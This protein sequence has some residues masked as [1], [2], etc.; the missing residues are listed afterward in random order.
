MLGQDAVIEHGGSRG[1][2][3]LR[4]RRWRF[5]LWIAAL[6]GI[7]V[8]VAPHITR[9]TVIAIAAVALAFYVLVGRELKS[10]LARHAA[11]VVAASQLLAVLV[12]IFAFVL[13]W[14][15][16]AAIAIFPAVALL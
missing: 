6:E 8:A 5:A 16:I 9:W 15:A 10:D 2:R 14:L 1:G 4:E 11:W 13:F 7:V 12:A 3:W